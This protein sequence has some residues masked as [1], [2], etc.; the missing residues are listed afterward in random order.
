MV[1]QTQQPTALFP[2]CPRQGKLI[3]EKG[4]PTVPWQYFFDQQ[5]NALQQNLK[6]E[7]FKLPP[8]TTAQQAAI[9]ALYTQYIGSPL[10]QNETGN[11]SGIFLQDISGQVI[12]DSS[13]RV[14]KIFII[15]YD[16]AMPPNII[17]ARWWTFTIT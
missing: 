14:P 12:F 6:N 15:T 10:P 11:V 8:L 13:A 3:D 17:S 2:D 9:T 5:T 16:G 1:A 4:F 7:G